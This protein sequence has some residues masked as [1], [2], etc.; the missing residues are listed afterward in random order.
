[1]PPAAVTP[2]MIATA[3]RPPLTS[4][5]TPKMTSLQSF[6]DLQNR[7]PSIPSVVQELIA[8]LQDEDVNLSTLVVRIKQDQALSARVLRLANSS[9]YGV[10]R[11]IAVI[12]DAVILIGLNA[13]RTL[14]IA[15]GVSQAFQQVPGVDLPSFW[16]HSLLTALLARELARRAHLGAEQAYTAGLMHRIGHLLIC[17]HHPEHAGF[18]DRTARDLSLAELL[19]SEYEHV[20]M[21]HCELGAAIAEH[22]NFPPMIQGA[23]RD[24]ADP[25]AEGANPYAGILAI[26]VM[27][28]Q[29]IADRDDDKMILDAIPAELLARLDLDRETLD[30]VLA[31][32]HALLTASAAF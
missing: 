27:M 29:G 31:N 12:D 32:R 24:Y 10:S 23:L 18:M 26:A 4:P 20:G 8:S 1:M 30:E 21:D 5:A 17:L 11:R 14:V 6:L 19:S 9:Y 28:A 13:L 3:V 16:R 2:R 25:L 22:W 15:S 7:L